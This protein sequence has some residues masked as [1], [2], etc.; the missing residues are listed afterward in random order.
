M[1]LLFPLQVVSCYAQ[2]PK[3]YV[4]LFHQGLSWYAFHCCQPILSKTHQLELNSETS[5][6]YHW[7]L[8]VFS[9]FYSFSKSAAFLFE[10]DII[11]LENMTSFTKMESEIGSISNIANKLIDFF[12][13]NDFIYIRGKPEKVAITYLAGDLIYL[14]SYILILSHYPK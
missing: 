14:K 8:K 1:F 7:L 9:K 6:D 3:W 10:N 11:Y 13:L 5:K 2:A 12:W 4:H